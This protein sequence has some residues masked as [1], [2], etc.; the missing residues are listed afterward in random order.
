MGDAIIG[1][2]GA[3]IGGL[4][5]VV[6]AGLQ[7]RN[8][9]SVQAKQLKAEERRRR[10]EEAERLRELRRAL[11]RRYLFQLDEAIHSLRHCLRN[12]RQEGGQ[13]WTA[14]RPGYWEVTSLYVFARALAAER[15]LALEGV[16]PELDA[17]WAESDVRLTPRAVEQAL[18]EAL[19]QEFFYLQRLRDATGIG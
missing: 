10:N 12:W 1:L 9:L 2:A 19:G 8:A 11:V 16:Y 4:A 6:G 15:L 13:E 18:D 17:L 3:L 14:R 7:A 5:A